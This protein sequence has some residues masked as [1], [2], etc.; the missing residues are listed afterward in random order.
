MV[1]QAYVVSRSCAMDE[2]LGLMFVSAGTLAIL[3]YLAHMAREGGGDHTKSRG[4]K[5][6]NSIEIMIYALG[7]VSISL[8]L[9][10]VLFAL[11]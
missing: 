2:L 7:G 9:G 10:A 3:A 11:W 1:F 8:V 5:K 4:M 6:D